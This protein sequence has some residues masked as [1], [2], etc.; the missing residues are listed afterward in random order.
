M[1]IARPLVRRGGV[2]RLLAASILV[3]LACTSLL[4]AGASATPTL[5][6]ARISIFGGPSQSFPAGQPFHFDHGWTVKPN[7]DDSLGL[8]SFSLTMDGVPV[9]PDFIEIRQ[10]DDPVF[11]HVLW[12]VF[13]FNF[14]N[15]LTGTH[16]FAGTWS[17]PCAEMVAQ[18]FATGPC[19]SPKAV[20]EAPGA[21]SATEVTF[22]P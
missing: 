18:G 14:P 16:V 6:G 13:V 7:K 15:G 3:T 10:L 1:K 12:R 8:W 20:V 11:G 5:V 9:N 17:G 19:V 4:V 2:R 22:V 21:A